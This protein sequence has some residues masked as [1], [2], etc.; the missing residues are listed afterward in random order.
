MNHF[1]GFLNL[2]DRPPSDSISDPQVRCLFLNAFD[3]MLLVDQRG[4]LAAANPAA[5]E[6]LGI[7]PDRPLSDR[8]EAFSPSEELATIAEKLAENDVL[9]GTGTVMGKNG[10]PRNVEY[11]AA[12][13]FTPDR[14]LLILKPIANYRQLETEFLDIQERHQLVIQGIGE[15]IWDWDCQR[16][17]A[18]VSPRY[19]E[20]QGYDPDEMGQESF[21]DFLDR[22]H[23][24]DLTS[25]YQVYGDYIAGR[26]SDYRVEFRQRTKTGE[27]KWILSV[28]KLVEWD[29]DG[30]PL[31]MIGTHTDIGA[32]K[33]M[34]SA[35]RESRR[36]LQD[37]LNSCAAHI[38][39]L[40]VFPD[41]TWEYVNRSGA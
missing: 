25:A 8:W 23:P 12:A 11:R 17:S 20:I 18:I 38:V 4:R 3:A 36:Q 2:S 19:W 6:L 13:N 39:Q 7:D 1:D 32:Y 24:D 34:E 5:C 28:G 37:V 31:R 10:R 21:S 22:L 16:D 14:H 40:W 33:Q 15:G 35:L 27:W 30:R 26:R 41:R 9:Q 29:R